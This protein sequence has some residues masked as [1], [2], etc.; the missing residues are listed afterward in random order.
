M[1]RQLRLEYEGAI[2]HVLARGNRRE[3]I[4]RDDRDRL[5]WLDYLQRQR[6]DKDKEVRT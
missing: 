1:P 5:A 6:G 4:Y 3:S 2:Y